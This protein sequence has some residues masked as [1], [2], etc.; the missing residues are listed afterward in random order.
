[1]RGG[2]QGGDGNT[3]VLDIDDGVGVDSKVCNKIQVIHDKNLQPVGFDS[4]SIQAPKR[5]FQQ[6]EEHGGSPT[7]SIS[8]KSRQLNI[9]ELFQQESTPSK[10]RPAAGQ[11]MCKD[12]PSQAR[13]ET[14]KEA[15]GQL[16][17][18][19]SDTAAKSTR[20]EKETTWSGSPN[21]HTAESSD[22]L[23]ADSFDTEAFH[24]PPSFNRGSRHRKATATKLSKLTD[25]LN[26][27]EKIAAAAIAAAAT[28]HS[29]QEDEFSGGIQPLD[30][31]SET[32]DKVPVPTP[33]PQAQASSF[34]TVG[35]L[36]SEMATL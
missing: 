7:L 8:R 22:T 10:E 25:Q 15:R 14:S 5:L 12:I 28:L 3:T 31:A 19:K 36:I 29:S 27:Q 11:A 35:N 20:M 6:Q 24:G 26:N 17:K 32:T 4:P 9:R 18:P 13:E 23:I 16:A 34:T 33:S 21:S 30:S 2:G 1:M